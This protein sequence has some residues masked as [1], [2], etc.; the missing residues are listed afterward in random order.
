VGWKET[1][2]GISQNRDWKAASPAARTQAVADVIHM[3]SLGAAAVS[4]TPVPLADLVI[5]L[6]LQAAMVVAIGHIQGRDVTREESLKIARELSTVVGTHV[7]AR[8]AFIALSRLLF[9]GMAGFLM[10]PWTYAVTYG[11]GRVAE[12]YFLDPHAPERELRERFKRGL[13]EARKLFSKDAFVDFMKGK[14]KDA[15]D[16]AK[17]ETAKPPKT[18]APPA[19]HTSTA[20]PVVEAAWE[21]DKPPRDQS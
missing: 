11:M 9:P 8:R 20:E 15:Q 21:D 10:A 12:M 18:D 5:A 17:G 1:L 6:P 19:P 7:L 3:S 14:G 13:D 2:E 16:F 4:V